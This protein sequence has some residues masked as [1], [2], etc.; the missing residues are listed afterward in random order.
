ML[1]ALSF[2][3]IGAALGAV[4]VAV[5][6]EESTRQPEVIPQGPP[7]SSLTCEGVAP[8]ALARVAQ[9][10]DEVRAL[11]ERNPAPVEVAAPAGAVT[12]E[13]VTVSEDERS[14]ALRWRVSAIEKFVP[15]TDE[16]KDRLRRKFTE[17]GNARVSG[18][19]SQAES[20]D[21]ILGEENARYYRE[22]VAAAFQRMQDA[23]I[24]KE[25]LLISRQLALP[26]EQEE[27]VRSVFVGVER[28][29]KETE[30]PRQEGSAHERVRGM[31]EENKRRTSLRGEEL[32]K[33]LTPEQ[34]QRYLTLEA[35]SP[36]A[37][38]EVFHDPGK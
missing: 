3:I 27:G 5:L 6:S 16:Q 13:P 31:V 12:V 9:L 15:L 33:I 1:K 36:A 29:L 37:D 20:L 28:T 11:R 18:G 24:E 10:E 26:V 17:E 22:Q 2:F 21:E 14:E 7:P 4:G 30:V 35:E 8:T 25:V 23:E 34:Y 19:E 38:V 32:K